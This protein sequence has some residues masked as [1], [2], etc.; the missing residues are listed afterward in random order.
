MA[1]HE[2]QDP[3]SPQDHQEHQEHQYPQSPQSAYSQ[4]PQ[5]LLSPQTPRE[6][7]EHQERQAQDEPPP[8]ATSQ[9][10]YPEVA[11]Q[12]DRYPEHNEYGY[13]EHSPSGAAYPAAYGGGA[14]T[15]YDS[16]VSPSVAQPPPPP[17]TVLFPSSQ[18]S[19]SQGGD[20]N[21]NNIKE[22]I[23]GG[24]G[25]KPPRGSTIWGCS[26]AVFVLAT[27]V[28]LLLAAVVGLAAGTGI[29]AR[30]AS[31]AA[32]QLAEL[33]ASA[34][35]AAAKTV[36]VTAPAP[37]ATPWA[38][39]DHKCSSDPDNVSGQTYTSFT[40]LGAQTF[41]I[42]CNKDTTGTDL[43]SLF[44][45]DFDACMDACSAFTMYETAN[46]G[47]ANANATCGAVS[48]IPLWTIKSDAQKGKA[49]GNCYLKPAPQSL[50]TLKT[51]NIGT[52]CHAAFVSRDK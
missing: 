12:G 13:G 49:P 28:A 32:D 9:S 16:T 34:S 3:R 5:D 22:E 44:V 43:L 51:P 8:R 47:S 40:L 15:F 42:Q 41:T 20:S 52:E 14:A 39:L 38:A 31:D 27:V 26:V 24:S 37:T 10:P 17:E 25:R 4:D 18:S 35:A 7:Q 21:S 30:R 50:K 11:P 6:P 45:A 33:S 19:S 23:A 29:E 46:F 2:H 1:D 48:F 36:T